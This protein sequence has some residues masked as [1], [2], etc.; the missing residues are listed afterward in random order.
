MPVLGKDAQ[1][2]ARVPCPLCRGT[3]N[4][5]QD[6]GGI[7]PCPQCSGEGYVQRWIS[8]SDLARALVQQLP[9]VLPR[10]PISF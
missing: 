5:Q 4:N 8:L 6:C 7:M 3:A 2:S 9:D 10:V 1:M